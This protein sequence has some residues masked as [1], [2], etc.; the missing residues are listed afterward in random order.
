MFK[1]W[2]PTWWKSNEVHRN[3][4]KFGTNCCL[5]NTEKTVSRL[6]LV[7]RIWY[8]WWLMLQNWREKLLLGCQFFDINILKVP[9]PWTLQHALSDLWWQLLDQHP[10][11][12]QKDGCT[13][14]TRR[15]Q[16]TLLVWRDFE[17]CSMR[18]RICQYLRIMLELKW[19]HNQ[20]W[21]NVRDELP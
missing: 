21:N 5:W 7:K 2:L 13:F 17:V 1:V 14:E 10:R 16:K 11:I 19:H 12:V 20:L 3:N 15:L 4:S 8:G 18:S 6:W 9:Q